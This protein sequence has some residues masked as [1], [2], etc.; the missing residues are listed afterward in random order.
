LILAQKGRNLAPENHRK[1]LWNSDLQTCDLSLFNPGDSLPISTAVH[2]LFSFVI[3]RREPALS[4]V[5]GA[6]A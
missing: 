6:H 3:L 5:E 1:P 2:A 4:E